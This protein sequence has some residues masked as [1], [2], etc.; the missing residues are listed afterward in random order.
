MTRQISISGYWRAYNDDFEERSH[1]IS[2]TTTPSEGGG[3][4]IKIAPGSTDISIM[5]RGLTKATAVLIM[6]DQDINVMLTG[7]HNA[8]FDVLANGVFAIGNASL[9]DVQV[10]NRNA[11]PT[12]N[13]F[14]D[15]TG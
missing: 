11:T 6:P 5:P 10:S 14:S 4:Q 13:V 8:S 15:I 2:V 12:A 3:G 1:R 7:V 9:S